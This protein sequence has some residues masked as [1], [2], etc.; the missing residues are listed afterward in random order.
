[1][2]IGETDQAGMHRVLWSAVGHN[3][4]RHFAGLLDYLIVYLNGNEVTVAGSNRA[5]SVA[6]DTIGE[7]NRTLGRELE[8]LFCGPGRP[9]AYGTGGD[10]SNFLPV[11]NALSLWLMADYRL[12]DGRHGHREYLRGVL[13]QANEG[14]HELGAPDI[15]LTFQPDLQF[16]ADAAFDRDLIAERLQ[17]LSFLNP[18]LWIELHH[19]AGTQQRSLSF[20]HPDGLAAYMR[21]LVAGQPVCTEPLVH[22]HVSGPDRVELA[23]QWTNTQVQHLA[24]YVNSCPCPPGHPLE[25]VFLE[26]MAEAGPG[27]SLGSPVSNAHRPMRGLVAIVSLWLKGDV[28]YDFHNTGP[29]RKDDFAS[30][31][32]AIKA[33][34]KSALT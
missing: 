20:H 8:T 32:M 29:W 16:F 33:A 34:V 4:E 12:P 5:F 9:M 30:P 14:R 6:G 27:H 24:L 18:Y 19:G 21:L 22:T 23:V 13:Q 7:C 31:S 28:R 15:A 11:T 26:A 17:T 25:Q 3:L 2:Y 10:F 1:M